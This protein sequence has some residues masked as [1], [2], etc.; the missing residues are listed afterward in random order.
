MTRNY[1][2]LVDAIITAMPTKEETAALTLEDMESLRRLGNT[3]D[4]FLYLDVT[5]RIKSAEAAKL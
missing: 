1:A 2:R 3:Y 4:N 5:R